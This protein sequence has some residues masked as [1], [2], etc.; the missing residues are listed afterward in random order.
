M[1]VES[2]VRQ[3]SIRIPTS[4]PLHKVPSC[5]CRERIFSVIVLGTVITSQTGHYTAFNFR[6]NA[7][8]RA[9]IMFDLFV[10]KTAPGHILD[11]ISD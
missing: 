7:V 11:M 5:T 3:W 6:V 1:P 4:V 9:T 2:C 8:D 10:K